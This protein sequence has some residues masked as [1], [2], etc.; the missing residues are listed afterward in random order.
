MSR[1]GLKRKPF[2]PGDS[3]HLYFNQ[4]IP[5]QLFNLMNLN[6]HSP[7]GFLLEVLSVVVEHPELYNQIRETMK[8]TESGRWYEFPEYHHLLNS[9]HPQNEDPDKI[10][11]RKTEDK[12]GWKK[13]H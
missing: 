5:S 9:N 4:E 13:D 7:N 12:I 2:H 1:V 6:L 8:Q 11:Q 10:S 3:F